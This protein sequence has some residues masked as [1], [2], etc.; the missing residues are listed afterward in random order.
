MKKEALIQEHWNNFEASTIAKDL[1]IRDKARLRM[2]FIAGMASSLRLL[3]LADKDKG[4]RI[5]ASIR[6]EVKE[7]GM[8]DY[9]SVYTRKK[10]E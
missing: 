7:Y 4:R 9:T 3:L 8:S 1:P 5:R 6:D 10:E 2:A